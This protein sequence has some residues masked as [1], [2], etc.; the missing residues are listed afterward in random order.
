MPNPMS[1]RKARSSED[2]S[3]SCLSCGIWNLFPHLAPR[4]D[5]K[6][7]RLCNDTAEVRRSEQTQ[8]TYLARSAV[9]RAPS[10]DS[11]GSLSASGASRFII[12]GWDSATMARL[13]LAWIAGSSAFAP[14]P[15]PAR[16]DWPGF[17]A[18]AGIARRSHERCPQD[19]RAPQSDRA[20]APF[21]LPHCRTRGRRTQ[22][23]AAK[24]VRDRRG[25]IRSVESGGRRVALPCVAAGCRPGPARDVR[26]TPCALRRDSSI[27]SRVAS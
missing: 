12:S 20:H 10:A 8:P 26:A 1:E 18:S 6:L 24:T 21:G 3:A 19:H 4:V 13:S 22:G 9:V 5:C 23:S 2:Q 7:S 15:T 14:R 11:S 17:R 16:S 25:W 27:K